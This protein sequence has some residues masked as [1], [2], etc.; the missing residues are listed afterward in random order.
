MVIQPT[1]RKEVWAL[2]ANTLSQFPFKR[3]DDVKKQHTNQLVT[4]ALSVSL[5][6]SDTKE[7]HAVTKAPGLTPCNFQLDLEKK[8]LTKSP[9]PPFLICRI[10]KIERN[11]VH[12]EERPLVTDLEPVMNQLPVFIDQ[13]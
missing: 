8:K 13:S 10:G 11:L 1:E 6:M 12:Q 5:G 4:S 9:T 3:K 7:T 2:F